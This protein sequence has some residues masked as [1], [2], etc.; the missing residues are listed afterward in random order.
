MKS[1]KKVGVANGITGSKEIKQAF[2]KRALGLS[3]CPLWKQLHC[4]CG[5][6]KMLYL[7]LSLAQNPYSAPRGPWSLL[8]HPHLSNLTSSTSS[9]HTFLFPLLPSTTVLFPALTSLPLPWCCCVWKFPHKG[10]HCSLLRHLQAEARVTCHLLCVA[11]PDNPAG[12]LPFSANTHS[13][14]LKRKPRAPHGVTCAK[15]PDNKP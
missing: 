11:F 3:P 1:C 15:A 13:I 2:E 6:F 12:V 10:P 8:T 9:P 7:P 4:N 5:T 14:P